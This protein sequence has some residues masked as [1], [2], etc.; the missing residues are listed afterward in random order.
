VTPA[1]AS[2]IDD[3]DTSSGLLARF[4][5]RGSP[6]GAAYTARMLAA[7][8]PTRARCRVRLFVAAAGRVAAIINPRSVDEA[9]RPIGLLGFFAHDE[10]GV[11]AAA[12]LARAVAWLAAQGCA[13]VRGPIDFTTWHTY[14]LVTRSAI[15]DVIP[16]E[17]VHPAWYPRLWEGA[18]FAPVTRYSSNW[19]DGE[20]V[21]AQLGVVAARCASRGHAVRPLAVADAPALFG[22]AA[23]CFAG[24]WMYSPIDGAEFAALYGAERAAAASASSLVAEKGG[25]LAGFMYNFDAVLDGERTSVCKTIGVRHR[26][27][28][29]GV[30][31]LLM[32]RWAEEARARGCTRLAG[33]LMH[34]DGSPGTLGWIRPETMI[35]E[36]AIYE[37]AV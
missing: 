27:R 28:A 5:E 22:L 6:D 18:G 14:R 1:V 35:R 15:R 25:E 23:E 9:G 4:I 11:A 2:A 21:I 10:D 19:L 30:Y 13:V 20:A 3:G 17:P 36:Y 29:A 37:R 34:A 33:A 12:L 31:P 26:S 8:H 24:A 32:C 16:G 7:D